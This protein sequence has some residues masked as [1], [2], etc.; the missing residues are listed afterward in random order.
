MAAVV[1]GLLL[2]GLLIWNTWYAA[3]SATTHNATD[4]WTTG[5]VALSDDDNGTALS[6][7]SGLRPGS[8]ASRCLVVPS[9]GTTDATV[10]TCGQ[11]LTSTTSLAS[12]PRLSITQGA[13]GG[14]GSC[15]GFTPGSGGTW[16]STLASFPTSYGAG[17]SPWVLDGTA[18]ETRRYQV[19]YTVDPNAP[20]STQDASA[21]VTLIWEAQTPSS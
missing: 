11:D 7:A 21:A 4:T 5:T 9:T 12:W 8:T 10:R 15:T 3:Y 13:G 16:S 17:G 6:T 18:P 14:A 20:N 19:T 2:S 1:A